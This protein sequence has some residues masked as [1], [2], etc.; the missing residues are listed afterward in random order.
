MGE[1]DQQHQEILNK[2]ATAEGAFKAT[3]YLGGILAVLAVSI[4]VYAFDKLER[5]EM[6]ISNH[7]SRLSVVESRVNIITKTKYE[8]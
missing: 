8:E 7:E 6:K 4:A 2:I 3:G 1:K 5:H